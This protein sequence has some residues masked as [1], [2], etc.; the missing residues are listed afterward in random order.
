MNGSSFVTALKP[1]R[2]SP[3]LCAHGR[4]NLKNP[5]LCPDTT[6]CFR[7]AMI[8]GTEALLVQFPKPGVAVS[9]KTNPVEE[10]GHE[11]TN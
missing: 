5:L 9:C 11:T 1:N 2:N 3:P 4:Y 6:T 8:D 7:P 10:L